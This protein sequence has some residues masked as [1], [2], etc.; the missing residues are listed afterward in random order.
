VANVEGDVSGAE[1]ALRRA[2]ELAES[3]EMSLHAA[4]ARFRLGALVGGDQGRAMIQ[5]AEVTMK[6]QGVRIPERYAQM[7]TPGLWPG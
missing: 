3:A 5:Q 1:G 2:I 4:A 6:T 7:L